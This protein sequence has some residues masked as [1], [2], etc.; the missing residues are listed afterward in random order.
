MIDIFEREFRDVR[1]GGEIVKAFGLNDSGN[2]VKKVLCL[3]ALKLSQRK[4]GVFNIQMSCDLNFYRTAVG[5]HHP[6]VFNDDAFQNL[7]VQPHAPNPEA[8]GAA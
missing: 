8:G 7:S 2:L 1:V 6:W 4:K 5:N 3:L